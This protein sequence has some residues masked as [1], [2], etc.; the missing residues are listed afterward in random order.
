MNNLIVKSAMK[1]FLTP[2]T[3]GKLLKYAAGQSAAVVIALLASAPG[4]LQ[5]IVTYLSE[6]TGIALDEASLTIFF[7]LI[8][9]AIVQEVVSRLNGIET[10]NIQK[11][12]DE[13]EDGWAGTR[14]A[15]AVI[16]MRRRLDGAL[17]EVEILREHINQQKTSG[18]SE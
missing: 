5:G 6:K 8:I 4:W 1:L 12:V 10:K 7:G 11:A 17:R 16:G 15:N 3:V 9:T 14:T 2:S 18:A 13:V